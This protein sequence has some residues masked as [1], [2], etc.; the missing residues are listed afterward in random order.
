[1]RRAGVGTA[2]AAAASVVVA[3]AACSHSPS[4]EARV[5]HAVEAPLGIHALVRCP[6]AA[7]GHAGAAF[8]CRATIDGRS[9]V[10]HVAVAEGGKVEAT[11]DGIVARADEVARRL[12]RQIEDTSALRPDAVDCG[13]GVLVVAAGETFQCAVTAGADRVALTVATS[14]EGDLSFQLAD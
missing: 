9:I 4:V 3:L 5:K 1:M 8:D 10:V 6:P 7:D 14:S 2:A 13:S 11:P 12:Q